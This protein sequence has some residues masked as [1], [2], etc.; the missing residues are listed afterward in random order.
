MRKKRN[1]LFNPGTLFHA[2]DSTDLLG[3]PRCGPGGGPL[4]G[5]PR[6]GGPRSLSE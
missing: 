2:R 3:G 4:N 6:E 5:G 1:T